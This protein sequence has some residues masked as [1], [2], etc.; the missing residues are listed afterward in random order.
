MP[1]FLG[2]FY[3]PN[4]YLAVKCCQQLLNGVETDVVFPVLNVAY[5]RAPNAGKFGQLNRR[6]LARQ[7]QRLEFCA[8]LLP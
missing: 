3:R 5:V 7:A 6:E 1:H 4:N 2:L 8:Y